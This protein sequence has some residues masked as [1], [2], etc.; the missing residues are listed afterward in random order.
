M[1][2]WILI[3]LTLAL[4]FSLV[5]CSE[6]PQKSAG[7]NEP[8]PPTLLSTYLTAEINDKAVMSSENNIELLIGIARDPEIEKQTA[9]L[10]ID[11]DNFT[12]LSPDDQVYKDK[13]EFVYEDF[14]ILKTY[15]NYNSS[16][17]NNSY[18]LNY[19]VGINH[20]KY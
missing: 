11:A 9:T 2:K 20:L 17:N 8:V 1:K 16:L 19:I 7:M 6:E 3:I 18:H 5:S 4:I 10:T 15:K 13:Y 14:T 12:I